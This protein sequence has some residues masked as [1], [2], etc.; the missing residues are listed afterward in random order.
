MRLSFFT[1]CCLPSVA[2]ASNPTSFLST[3]RWEIIFPFFA[4]L[5]MIGIVSF[6]VS[7]KKLGMKE[8][9]EHEVG[10]RFLI[11][12]TLLADAAIGTFLCLNTV[13]GFVWFLGWAAIPFTMYTLLV[14]I[15]AP[16]PL[17][18]TTG[19]WSICTGYGLGYIV[20]LGGWMYLA[21]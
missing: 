10:Y 14:F 19:E 20:F 3:T 7:N 15:R 21:R 13:H 8:T 2:Y 11:A 17:N 9:E 4:V 1:A 5:H 6:L 16:N 12:I 18:A